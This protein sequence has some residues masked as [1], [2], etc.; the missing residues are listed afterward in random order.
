MYFYYCYLLGYLPRKKQHKPLSPEMRQACR[1]L[2]RYSQEIRLIC[3]EKL[4]N[5]DDVHNFIDTS[6]QQICLLENER[7][8]IYNKLRR[9]TDPDVKSELLS[10]RDS[11]TS[12]L[13]LFRNDVRTANNILADNKEIKKNIKVENSMQQQKFIVK[14][15][16]RP[17]Y[18]DY[19]R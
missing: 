2:D 10:K 12:A 19:E 5:L 1:K 9:C 4:D 3:R 18:R 6:K 17:C 15:K 8:H 14:N 7:Q 11:Y 13:K 16:Q